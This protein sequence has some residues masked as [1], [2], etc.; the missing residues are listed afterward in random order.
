MLGAFSDD[1]P[2]LIGDFS[3]LVNIDGL[4]VFINATHGAQITQRRLL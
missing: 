2:G 4:L 3:A 1:F